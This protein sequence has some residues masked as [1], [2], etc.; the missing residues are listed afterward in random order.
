MNGSKF[1]FRLYLLT[2]CLSHVN[3]SK[4]F[5]ESQVINLFTKIIE[6]WQYSD[7]I[8]FIPVYLLEWVKPDFIMIDFYYMY[9]KPIFFSDYFYILVYWTGRL[10]QNKREGVYSEAKKSNNILHETLWFYGC[11]WS[12]VYHGHF[13]LVWFCA[14]TW[15][16]ILTLNV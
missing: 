1:T 7:I 9:L 16:Q 13:F 11:K 4:M 12:S 5:L 10:L 14:I 3:E 8:Y 15:L 2:D 6:F